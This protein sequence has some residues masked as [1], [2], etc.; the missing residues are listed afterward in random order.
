MS[1]LTPRIILIAALLALAVSTTPGGLRADE[2]SLIRWTAEQARDAG[3]M[4]RPIAP[5]S[6]LAQEIVLPGTVVV[7]PKAMAIVSSPLPA[8]VQ[9]IFV[10]AGDDVAEGDRIVRLASREILEWQR[11]LR[12][13]EVQESLASRRLAR[14]EQLFAE[15][16]ISAARLQDTRSEHRI[17]RLAADERRRALRLAGAGRSRDD[18]DPSL[19]LT[20]SAAGTVIEV[21]A[22]PGQRVEPGV[23]IVRLARIGALAVEIQAST[24]L[25]ARIRPGDRVMIEGCDTPARIGSIQPLVSAD[26]QAVRIR[27]DLESSGACLRINQFVRVRVAGTA[28]A[29]AARIDVPAASIVRHQGRAWV[30]VRSADGFLARPVTLGTAAGDRVAVLSGLSGGEDI[31]TAGIAALKGAWLGLGADAK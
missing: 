18:F 11:D 29:E 13:A 12:Q 9:E 16:L 30:F 5:P 26:N 4:T 8:V 23:A 14:D 22:A 2:T 24:D 10:S 28:G 15:G 6:T 27:A 25:A 20:A 31:A 17:A 1:I 3:V 19:L 21:Q 7:P